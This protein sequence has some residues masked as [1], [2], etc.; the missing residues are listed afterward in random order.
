M[1]SQLTLLTA[2]TDG[3]SITTPR[4]R[5]AMIE[6]ADPISIAIESETKLRRPLRLRKVLV[7]PINDI[8][9]YPV[10]LEPCVVLKRPARHLPIDFPELHGLF[11]ILH[12]DRIARFQLVTTMSGPGSC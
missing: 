7:L 11:A 10:F 8:K 2:T 3:S 12:H 5:T 9:T 6:L 4:P 1:T